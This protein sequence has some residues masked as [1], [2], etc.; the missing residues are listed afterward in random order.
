MDRNA[1]RPQH[2]ATLHQ[3]QR[4][5]AIAMAHP[6][7][8]ILRRRRRPARRLSPATVRSRLT[9]TRLG[10][11]RTPGPDVGSQAGATH[12][13]WP[14]RRP[15]S[16]RLARFPSAS[17]WTRRE[18]QILALL[19]QRLSNPEIATRLFVSPRTVST[20]VTRVLTKLGVTN[21]REAAL[22]ALQAGLVV[23]CPHCA[24]PYAA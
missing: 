6:A 10:A 16:G 22:L 11:D 9:W 17:S 5:T 19:C 7:P 20:H 1:H 13:R 21:R 23:A 8:R 4:R 2:R 12:P 18:R 24:S 15:P 3:A 14:P